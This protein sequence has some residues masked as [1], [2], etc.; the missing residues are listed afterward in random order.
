VR[1]AD[2]RLGTLGWRRRRGLR[3][4]SDL[5]VLLYRIRRGFP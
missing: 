4:G 2:R 3:R 1:I 5:R